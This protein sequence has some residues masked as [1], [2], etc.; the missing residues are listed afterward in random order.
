MNLDVFQE[1]SSKPLDVSLEEQW[2]RFRYQ[3]QKYSHA[4]LNSD[5]KYKNLYPRMTLKSFRRLKPH[6]QHLELVELEFCGSEAL[7]P[8]ARYIYI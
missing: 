2:V 6:P 3:W 7:N 8:Q 5:D 1:E 4:S